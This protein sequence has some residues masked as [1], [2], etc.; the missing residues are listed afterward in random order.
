MHPNSALGS[1]RITAVMTRS[2]AGLGIASHT[3]TLL[4]RATG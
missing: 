4:E 1:V 2:M 3:F